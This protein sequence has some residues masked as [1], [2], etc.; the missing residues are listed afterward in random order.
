MRS[1]CLGAVAR[2]TTIGSALHVSSCLSRP[3]WRVPRA[4]R[5]V[6][7][8]STLQKP[9]RAL[10]RDLKGPYG[11]G[12]AATRLTAVCGA[13]TP[14][15]GADSQGAGPSGLRAMLPW[16]SAALCTHMWDRCA[17]RAAPGPSAPPP[18]AASEGARKGPGA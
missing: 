5:R 17:R 3:R 1:A 11:E 9:R 6:R 4:G 14:S 8:L 16:V 7:A 12:A 18:Q 15:Q 13:A 2:H 10:A